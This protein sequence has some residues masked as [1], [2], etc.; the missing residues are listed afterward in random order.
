M[1][2]LA[3]LLA[4]APGWPAALAQDSP[5]RDWS[6]EKCRRYREASERLGIKLENLKMVICRAR[7]KIY[8]LISDLAGGD[9]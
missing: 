8:R 5:P 7:K 6:A 9:E 2:A 4:P 1:M 3:L